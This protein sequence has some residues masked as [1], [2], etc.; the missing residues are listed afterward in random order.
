LEIARTGDCGLTEKLDSNG[1]FCSIIIDPS[2]KFSIREVRT[3]YIFNLP[4]SHLSTS[5]ER[6]C[7]GKKRGIFEWDNVSPSLSCLLI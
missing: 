5:K 4:L 1:Y 2:I 3:E 7:E 6:V